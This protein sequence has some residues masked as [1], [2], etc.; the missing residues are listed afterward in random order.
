[1]SSI[2]LLCEF[3]TEK[4]RQEITRVRIKIKELD[5]FVGI[6]LALTLE[7]FLHL[8]VKSLHQRRWKED[9]ELEGRLLSLGDL[10]QLPLIKEK[11]KANLTKVTN[12][13]QSG[14]RFP[15]VDSHS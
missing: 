7:D 8:H 1:M 10:S 3:P 2:R 9:E 15:E 12:E 13:R 4:I 6:L 11:T 5:P 14:G